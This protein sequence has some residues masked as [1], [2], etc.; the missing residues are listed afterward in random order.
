M[1]QVLAQYPDV[2]TDEDRVSYRAHACGA[3]M[4]DGKWQGWLEFIPL[5][6]SAPIR[7][8]RETTQPNRTD[9]EYWATGLTV[10][11]LQGALQRALH[12]LVRTKVMRDDPA[13]TEPAPPLVQSIPRQTPPDAVLNPFHVYERGEGPLRGQLNALSAWHLVN[14]I[15]AYR[16][17]AKPDTTLNRLPASAL[18][19]MIVLSVREQR[20]AG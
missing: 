13:Y 7:S 4:P 8:G 6:G 2:L 12:P 20:L 9:T 5:D 18:I 16:L 15:R 14:I 1:A 11:Y 17:S 3:P 10:V 19:E